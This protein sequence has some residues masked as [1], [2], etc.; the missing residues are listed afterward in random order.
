MMSSAFSLSFPTPM[1]RIVLI[2]YRGGLSSWLIQSA[3][4]PLNQILAV[5]ALFNATNTQHMAL[6][7]TD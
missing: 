2:V 1:H 3:F 4:V 7:S 6:L 5:E